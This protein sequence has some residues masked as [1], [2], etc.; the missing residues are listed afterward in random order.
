MRDLDPESRR[1]T[2][3]IRSSGET[4][5]RVIDDILD[6]SKIE[7]GKLEI[8]HV[9]VDMAAV[10]TELVDLYRSQ[11]EIR[12]IYLRTDLPKDGLPM[13][14]C[15][16]VRIRQIVGNLVSNAIKFTSVGGVRVSVD[17][18]RTEPGK[19]T[20]LIGIHDTG[21]GIKA[22]KQSAIF[23][24]FTQAEGSTTRKY[25]GTGLGL[26]ICKRLTELMGGQIFVSSEPESG[27]TF[28]VRLNLEV[29]SEEMLTA[30]AEEQ[31]LPQGMRVLLAEDNDVNLMIATALLEDLGCEV[32]SV[33]DGESAIEAA[34]RNRYDAVLMDVHMPKCNGFDATKAIREL[35]EG[36]NLPII[37]LTAS[38]LPQDREACLEAGMSG[39]LSKP[40]TRDALART[41][42]AY[43]G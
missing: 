12:G 37:A 41:L 10:I 35:P 43:A 34:T 2:G 30:R 29:P 23:D 36:A 42:K 24:T 8:E 25:G 19:V 5:L 9:P 11:A 32:V 6:F 26:A 40:F 39:F 15:D 4:L 20:L 17:P 18:R 13:V 14:L 16:P 22:D 38:A 33:S 21:I 28:T 27:S 31:A 7:A 3:V 1:L